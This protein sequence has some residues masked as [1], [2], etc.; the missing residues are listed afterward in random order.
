MQPSETTQDACG[1]RNEVATATRRRARL[2][3][4]VPT[5]ASRQRD[6][7]RVDEVRER[8]ME[9]PMSGDTREQRCP[10]CGRGTLSDLAFD[11]T[12]NER[13]PKQTADSREV[14][15]YSCGHEVVGSSLAGADQERLDV[16]RRT[17]D[18]T[19]THGDEASS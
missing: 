5:G 8:G 17:S 2:S 10:V 9:D 6:G 3:S 11:E 15:T 12:G 14:V 7:A 19:T 1:G 16:E 13:A 18:E 4:W